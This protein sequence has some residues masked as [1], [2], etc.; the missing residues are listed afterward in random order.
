MRRR[1]IRFPWKRNLR[2]VLD[3]IVA[4]AQGFADEEIAVTC[5]KRVSGSE[6]R[7]RRYAHLGIEL[8]G[9]DLRFPDKRLP[10]PA[11]GKYSARNSFGYTLIRKDLPK[12][13]K[14]Y[15][16]EV[17][18]FGDWSKGSHT[19]NMDREVYRRDAIPPQGSEI[20]IEL[21]EEENSEGRSFVFKFRVNETINRSNPNFRR[22]LLFNLNLLQ[23][24]VGTVDI[25]PANAT[26]ADYLSTIQINWEILPPGERGP[27]LAR[28]LSGVRMPSPEV[29]RR[30]EERYDLLE[31]LQ[32]V[33]FVNGTGGFS[34]YFGAKFADDLVVLENVE[35]GNAIYVMFGE[36]ETLSQ[37]SRTE[38][39][40]GDT[41]GFVRIT[42]RPG[43][44]SQLRKVVEQK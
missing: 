6:V 34:R 42:H 33:A 21:L 22:D 10:N 24:N 35:Y 28:M 20:E 43:W 14:T 19:I 12:I 11:A 27:N 15:S 2:K 7:A 25:F 44:E 16:M 5:V 31:E 36:W 37:K 40:E 9:D 30:F 29:R 39:L 26:L 13:T 41:N 38:L 1:Y 3:W 4:K 18:N 8:Q 17:P 32:P 23:E